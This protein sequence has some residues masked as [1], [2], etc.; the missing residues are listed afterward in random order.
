MAQFSSRFGSLSSSFISNSD[1]RA[2]SV[3]RYRNHGGQRVT[4]TVEFLDDDIKD[5]SPGFEGT[6]ANGNEVW[7]YTDQIETIVKR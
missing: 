5:G 4:V 2:G 6:D 7:G 1:L 3:V